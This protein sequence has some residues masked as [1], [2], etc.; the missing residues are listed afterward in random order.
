MNA[1]SF[2]ESY[3]P[4]ALKSQHFAQKTHVNIILPLAI[5]TNYPLKLYF[6]CFYLFLFLSNRGDSLTNT[7]SQTLKCVCEKVTQST[8]LDTV[9]E[10]EGRF[11]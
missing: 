3:T 7:G 2:K 8:P 10:E 4:T 9:L 1:H 11:P 5:T 6:L